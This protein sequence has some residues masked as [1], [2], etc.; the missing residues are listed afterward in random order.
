MNNTYYLSIKFLA[1]LAIYIECRSRRTHKENGGLEE[2]RLL[3]IGTLNRK[4]LRFRLNFNHFIE[5]RGHRLRN[6]YP[7]PRR[8][9]G[10][11][12]KKFRHGVTILKRIIMKGLRIE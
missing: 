3:K 6:P 8:I 11:K 2:W 10:K 1:L 4:V 7:L 12:S 9:G 5:R